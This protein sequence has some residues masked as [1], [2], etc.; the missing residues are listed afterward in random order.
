MIMQSRDSD[1]EFVSDI[2]QSPQ[3]SALTYVDAPLE[4]WR[5]LPRNTG[6]RYLCTDILHGIG[7]PMP[8]LVQGHGFLAT[9]ATSAADGLFFG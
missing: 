7:S 8:H 2:L 5:F 3:S 4:D 1:V 6:R 9:S